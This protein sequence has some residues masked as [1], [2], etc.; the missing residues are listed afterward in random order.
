[1]V[2]GIRTTFPQNTL[3]NQQ[4]TPYSDS[5]EFGMAIALIHAVGWGVDPAFGKDLRSLLLPGLPV[6]RRRRKDK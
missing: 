5:T 4:L 6:G 3:D 2:S 1:L